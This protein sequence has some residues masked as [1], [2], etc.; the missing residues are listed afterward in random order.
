MCSSV[1]PP[2]S[3]LYFNDVLGVCADVDGFDFF[4][5]PHVMVRVRALPSDA[6]IVAR[7]DDVMRGGGCFQSLRV[8][9]MFVLC[10]RVYLKCWYEKV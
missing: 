10:Y 2:R 9:Y 6:R 8:F 1:K 5:D 3:T 7:Y 4:F